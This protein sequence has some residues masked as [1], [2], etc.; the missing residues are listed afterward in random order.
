MVWEDQR[1]SQ[2]HIFSQPS[3]KDNNL[4]DVVWRKWLDTMVHG[5][6]FCFVPV[7]ADN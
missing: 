7:E 6:G 4:C 5:V 2:H 3:S 1:V